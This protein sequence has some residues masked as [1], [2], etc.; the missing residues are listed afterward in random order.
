MSCAEIEFGELY[1]SLHS[2]G[3]G[4]KPSLTLTPLLFAPLNSVL[5]ALSQLLF[6]LPFILLYLFSLGLL[7]SSIGESQSY[8]FLPTCACH[9]GLISECWTRGGDLMVLKGVLLIKE[10]SHLNLDGGFQVWL[11]SA[12]F[13]RTLDETFKDKLLYLEGG[14]VTCASSFL[15][16]CLFALLIMKCR[17]LNHWRGGKQGCI[18]FFFFLKIKAR[19]VET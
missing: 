10:R 18:H 1:S 2:R 14:E 15:L 5:I 7:L 3:R 13:M 19:N 9:G 16:S 4:Q 12:W 17:L 6:H 11:A 8:S